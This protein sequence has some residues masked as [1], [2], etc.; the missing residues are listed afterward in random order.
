MRFSVI[1]CTYN[2]AHLLPD[3]LRTLAAQTFPDFELLIVDDGSTDHTEEVVRRFAS[4]FANCT[5]LPKT[6]TGTADSRNFGVRAVSGSH[7]AFLDADDLWSP[8]YLRC[9]QAVFQNHPQAELVCCDGYSIHSSGTVLCPKYPPGLTPVE[10]PLLGGRDQ[11]LFFRYASPSA[12]VFTKSLYD[13]VG[14]F[15]MRFPYLGED[16]HW[17]LRAITQGAFCFRLDRKL[18]LYREHHAS[19]TSQQDKLF[20][21]WLS[22]YADVMQGNVL[23]EQFRLCAA[24]FTRRWLAGLLGQCSAA[25]SRE[26][27]Q[28]ALETFPHDGLLQAARCGTYFGLCPLAWCARTTKRFVSDHLAPKPRID[29]GASPEA[30]FAFTSE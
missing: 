13:R 30:M 15:D 1:I 7:L 5:Y 19:L 17:V 8:E 6:H 26:L 24:R 2:Y 28:Q 3:A 23:N 14:P 22:L 11:F 20:Q 9:M 10:G 21:A 4:Q 25:K 18:M 27:L 16:W 12:T 29:L